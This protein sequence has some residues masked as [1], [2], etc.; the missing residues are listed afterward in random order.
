MDVPFGNPLPANLLTSMVTPAV[1]ISAAGT[2]VF[3]T[4]SRLA[5][6]IDRARE[7][8]RMLEAID[9][10]PDDPFAAERR[11]EVERQLTVRARRSHLVQS[12][13][14]RFYFAL[15]CFV[16]ATVALGLASLFPILAWLPGA[17]GITGTAILFA[18]CVQLIRET[19][20]AV[21]AVDEEMAFTLR[22]GELRR[23]GKTPSGTAAD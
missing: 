12:A 23:S 21:D 2:L 18:G 19:R 22:L 14:T 17:V 6:I 5:R 3:S 8:G 16:A 9:R 7:L 1:L 13:V 4:T 11:A 20:V 15:G 10:A